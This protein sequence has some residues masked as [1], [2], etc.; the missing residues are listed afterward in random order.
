MLRI[1]LEGLLV[2]LLGVVPV[3]TEFREPAEIEAG[4][5]LHA[6]LVERVARLLRAFAVI[7][8]QFEVAVQF[9]SDLLEKCDRSFIF[10]NCR[11]RIV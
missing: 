1:E 8:E 7:A 3:E 10:E 2:E 5:V 6:E 11:Q 9:W 4:H